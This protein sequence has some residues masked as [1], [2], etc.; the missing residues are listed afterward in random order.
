MHI[1]YQGDCYHVEEAGT[2]QTYLQKQD[3]TF[4][5]YYQA[6]CISQATDGTYSMKTGSF[7]SKYAKNIQDTS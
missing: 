5:Q 6:T 1:H 2:T 3:I 7:C 4:I